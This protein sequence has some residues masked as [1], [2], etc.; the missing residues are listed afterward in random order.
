MILG[1]RENEEDVGNATLNNLR[2]FSVFVEN[3]TQN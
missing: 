2:Q 1:L 3:T